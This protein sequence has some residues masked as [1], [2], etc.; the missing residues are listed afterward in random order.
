MIFQDFK[1]VT[2]TPVWNIAIITTYLALIILEQMAGEE[3]KPVAFIKLTCVLS[4]QRISNAVLLKS[5][6]YYDILRSLIISIKN[7]T[8]TIIIIIVLLTLFLTCNAL[9]FKV[10]LKTCYLKH[11]SKLN[12][13]I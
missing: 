3:F 5:L 13:K 12:R 8:G 9:E 11:Q 2:I 6:F 7:I 4:F 1:Q 10:N